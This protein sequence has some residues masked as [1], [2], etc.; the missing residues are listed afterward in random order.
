MTKSPITIATAQSYISKD[1]RENGLEIRSLMARAHAKGAR[2]INFPEG[3]MSGYVK[4]QIHDWSEVDWQVLREELEQTSALAKELKIWVALGC[5]HQLSEP[6]RPHNSIYII[7]DEGNIHTRYD[8]QW[9]S[10]NETHNWYTPGKHLTTFEVDG[11]K[12][13]CAI[14]VEIQFPELFLA[15]G[16]EQIDCML[17]SVYRDDTMFGIQAQAY[18]ATNNFWFSLSSAQQASNNLPS[19]MIGP[20]GYIQTSCQPNESTVCLSTLDMSE[21]SYDI[22]LHKARPWRAIVRNTDFY[23]SANITDERSSNKNSF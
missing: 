11:W 14:C 7:S 18:A 19:K 2:L 10:Y 22:A 6:H 20:S 5:N 17:Y 12:F 3:A 9:C 15:Y 16:A 8:K 21:P 23:K 13:G 4:A 1:V